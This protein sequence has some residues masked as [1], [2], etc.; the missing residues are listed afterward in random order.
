MAEQFAVVPPQDPRASIALGWAAPIIAME[1]P[2]RASR[3][4]APSLALQ[5]QAFSPRHPNV[6]GV[7]QELAVMLLRTGQ[8]AEATAL[9]REVV[10]HTE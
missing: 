8:T 4:C 3:C 1:N 6:I 10:A 7:K 5:L 2:A 9:I